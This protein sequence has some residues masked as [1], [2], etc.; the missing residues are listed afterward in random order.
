MLKIFLKPGRWRFVIAWKYIDKTAAA[1]AAIRDYTKMRSVINI[2]PEDIKELYSRMVSPRNGKITG[3]PKSKNNRSHE[4][5]VAA[6]LDELDV[7]QERY[8][9]AIE[10]TGWF[11]PAWASLTDDEQLVL[12]EFYMGENLRSGAG[13]RLEACLNYGRAQ[14]DRCRS[15]ALSRLSLLLFGR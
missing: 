13:T 9:Q 6:S 5:M 3:M 11:E 14:V 4:D 1:I 12:R 10:Y 7:M 15:K 8:R 2:T